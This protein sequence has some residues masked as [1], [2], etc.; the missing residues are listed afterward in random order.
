MTSTNITFTDP[1]ELRRELNAA[2]AARIGRQPLEDGDR[3]TVRP[4]GE[5]REAARKIAVKG[6]GCEHCAAVPEDSGHINHLPGSDWHGWERVELEDG[7]GEWREREAVPAAPA[8][9]REVTLTYSATRRVDPLSEMTGDT[10]RKVIDAA[11]LMRQ[12]RRAADRWVSGGYWER[13]DCISYVVSRIMA[14]VANRAHASGAKDAVRDLMA[15]QIPAELAAPGVL[16]NRVRSWAD[17]EQARRMAELQS[18]GS[19]DDD[20]PDSDDDMSEED[21]DR[22]APAADTTPPAWVLP[23]EQARRAAL[24]LAHRLGVGE[25]GGVWESFY[26]LLRDIDAREGAAELNIDPAAMRQRTSRGARWIR[27]HL[28]T[29]GDFAAALDMMTRDDSREAKRTVERGLWR[30]A[31]CQ[32]APRREGN[33]T[34]DQ[35]PIPADIFDRHTDGRTHDM[36]ATFSLELAVSHAVRNTG[37]L[38]HAIH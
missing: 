16:K 20:A 22:S 38:A 15:R 34:H 27:T 24:G 6:C 37:E 2:A 28:P 32:Q 18:A 26:L 3:F 19:G 21:L 11:E 10:D 17:R 13:E 9:R 25:L 23:A 1:A 8:P 12:V 36:R 29:P 7:R 35:R 14:E 5:Y 33:R 30:R 4:S 31:A